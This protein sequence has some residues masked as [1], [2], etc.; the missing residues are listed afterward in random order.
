MNFENK[1]ILVTGG[2]RGIGRATAT[3]F[4]KLGAKVVINY[5]SN[6]AAAESLVSEFPTTITAIRADVANQSEVEGM[7]RQVAD[8][9]GRIDVLVNNAGIV[10]DIPF[11]SSTTDQWR[12]TFDVNVLGVFLCSRAC[13]R[14]FPKDGGAIVNLGSVSG[15]DIFTPES[16]AYDATKAAI[17]SVTKGL[18]KEFAPQGVRVNA[19]APGW[20][21]TDMNK[22]LPAEFLAESIAR[23]YLKRMAK[24][25]EIAKA[26][27]FLASDGASFINGATL[28]VDGG[29]G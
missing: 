8:A 25:S 21:D 20:V 22:D 14:Y 18:A 11:V 7:V 2:N 4:A 16:M 26:I 3:E 9:Y 27:V 5:V 28:V 15:V 23:I 19:V 10:F 29:Y 24:P 1:V 12:R 17:V 13:L 6:Q